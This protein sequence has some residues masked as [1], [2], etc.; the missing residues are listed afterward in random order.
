MKILVANHH[1]MKTGGTENYTYTLACELKRL[2]H[3][4]EYFAFYRG[5]VAG[6]L[7]SEGISYMRLKSYDLVFASHVTTCYYLSKHLNGCP[8]VQ[9]CHGKTHFLEQPSPFADAHVA[10]SE[11]IQLHLRKQGY[12]SV[13]IR[14]GIDCRRF[15]PKRPLSEHL[16][17]VLLMCQGRDA[18]NIVRESC[19]RL[20]IKVLTA[21][22][23][24]DNLWNVEDRINQ[25][26]MLIGIGRSLYDGMACGRPAISFDSR[27]YLMDRPFGDGYITRDMIR[28]SI[29]KNCCGGI[30]KRFFDVDSFTEELK[31]YNPADGQWM[32]EFA[33]EELNITR[34]AQSYIAILSDKALLSSPKPAATE[35]YVARI[36]RYFHDDVLGLC[37]ACIKSHDYGNAEAWGMVN[38]YTETAVPYKMRLGMQVKFL[39]YRFVKN[40][41][42]QDSSKSL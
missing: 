41:T 24:T 37:R 23:D 22:K 25:A 39:W 8:I 13:V 36:D 17:T 1:L 10:V 16:S 40:S 33:L 19:S 2:G 12:A 35:D 9:T 27:P 18:C 32:R 14:N 38:A 3:E 20:G 15:S 34:M 42:C 21:D 11:N 31:K 30:Y 7:E 29:R 5:M 28:H 6:R 4:V 26:D